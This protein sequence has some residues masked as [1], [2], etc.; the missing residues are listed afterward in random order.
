MVENKTL[1]GFGSEE[2]FVIMWENSDSGT[3]IKMAVELN[4]CK[5]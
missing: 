1:S 4:C 2:M 5:E 3:R